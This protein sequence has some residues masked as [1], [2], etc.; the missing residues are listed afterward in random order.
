[1][2]I[3]NLDDQADKLQTV[4]KAAKVDE[5]EPIWTTLFAKVGTYWPD[6]I[7]ANVECLHSLRLL[8]ARMSKICC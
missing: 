6:T 5:V 1:M 7:T 8:R 2:K 4:I 3:A